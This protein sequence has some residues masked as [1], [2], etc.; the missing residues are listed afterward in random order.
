MRRAC[1]PRR[2]GRAGKEAR[3]E[4]ADG[5]PHFDA[6]VSLQ[7]SS[8]LLD[9]GL[10]RALPSP[11][12]WCGP[13]PGH[14]RSDGHADPRVH[15]VRLGGPAV[16]LGR[17]ACHDGPRAPSFDSCICVPVESPEGGVLGTLER[18]Q[19]SR[20]SLTLFNSYVGFYIGASTGKMGII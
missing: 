11:A 18:T 10:S 9:Q 12:P 2:G 19:L 4:W 7:T 16:V 3:Y 6:L 17:E 14:A 13:S 1:P 8:S 5:A 15:A 20:T